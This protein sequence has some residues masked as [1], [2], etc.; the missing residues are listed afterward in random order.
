MFFFQIA[1]QNRVFVFQW[2][3]GHRAEVVGS[4]RLLLGEHNEVILGNIVDGV[5]M[6]EW[7]ARTPAAQ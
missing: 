3:Y 6:I 2:N 5:E 1:E 4:G 7:D